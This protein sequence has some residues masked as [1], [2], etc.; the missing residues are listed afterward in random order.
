MA[1][2]YT[3]SAERPCGEE[4]IS[5]GELEKQIVSW[6]PHSSESTDNLV[7]LLHKWSLDCIEVL[8]F[9]DDQGRTLVFE[10]HPNRVI[11]MIPSATEIF[12]AIGAGEKVIGVDMNSDY[13]EEMTTKKDEGR[14]SEVGSFYQ[15]NYELLITLE[16]DLLVTTKFIDTEVLERME[17]LGLKV[18]LLETTSIED[19]YSD[20][21]ALGDIV[22]N[23]A[24]AAIL[25]AGLRERS[26]AVA[27]KTATLSDSERPT[28]LF[29]IWYSPLWTQGQGTFID[30]LIV[31]AGGK[32]I[33]GDIEG[34]GIIGLETVVSRDPHWIL[35]GSSDVNTLSYQNLLEEPALSHL[36]AFK[37]DRILAFNE[38]LIKRP[39]P[40]MIDALEEMAAILHPE[41]FD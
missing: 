38:D 19:L 25:I 14:I 18:F 4:E 5:T 40:R 3:A 35:V 21:E 39:G 31:K 30:D 20:I 13:P 27:E 2:I 41:V 28:T 34:Y 9:I 8:T 7:E 15:P 23:D 33:A 37:G 6:D 36:E 17:E 26:D 24:E 32:N 29:V 10:G 12:F 1:L 11:S 22:G 16:P